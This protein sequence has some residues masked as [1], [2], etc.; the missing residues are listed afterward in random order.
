M[1]REMISKEEQTKA[2]IELLKGYGL[3]QKE[4]QKRSIRNKRYYQRHRAKRK[5]LDVESHDVIEK[6]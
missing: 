1:V 5:G 3:Y 6:K 4:K 2:F